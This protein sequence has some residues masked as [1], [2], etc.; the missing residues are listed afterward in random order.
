MSTEKSML[1]SIASDSLYTTFSNTMTIEYS[2]EIFK[3]YLKEGSILELGPAEGLMTRELVKFTT[4]ITLVEGSDVFVAQLREKYPST[5]VV[6]TLFEDFN[7]LRKYDNIILGHVL[8][9]VND[10]VYILTI[11]KKWLNPGGRILSA[12]PNSRSLHRQAAVIMDLLDKEDS[13]SE[14]DFHHGH[15]RIYNPE[16]FRSDFK[17]AGLNII[18]FGGYW[19]KPISNK[20]IH[21]QWTPSMLHAFMQL[22]ERYPDV[23]GEIYIIASH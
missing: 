3:R 4:D 2:F 20:Q 15:R 1:N 5:E 16:S 19:L 7:P 13:M 14:L 18:A 11:A 8:E 10:P 6:N 17:A 12:V 21:E 22:G 9:H 23:A